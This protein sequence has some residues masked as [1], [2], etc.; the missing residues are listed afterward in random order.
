MLT[1]EQITEIYESSLEDSPSAGLDVRE[2]NNSIRDALDAYCS[3]IQY[4][5]FLWAYE[6]GY[7]AG[8]GITEK[9]QDHITETLSKLDERYI[10][11]VMVYA[12]TLY[13]IQEEENHE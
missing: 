8:R 3:A 10:R 9:M 2:A 13:K 1:K 7:N 5:T 4:E 6:L 11:N 12:D